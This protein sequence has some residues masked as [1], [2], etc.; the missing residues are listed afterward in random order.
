MLRESD[1]PAGY[2]FTS[3]RSE[4]G[5]AARY[6]AVDRECELDP[7]VASTGTPPD[8][9]SAGFRGAGGHGTEILYTFASTTSAVT[10]FRNFDR[11]F[12]GLG[13]CGKAISPNGAIGTYEALALG[14]V[15]DERSGLA[16]DPSGRVPHAREDSRPT[17]GMTTRSRAAAVPEHWSM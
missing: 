12:E 15:G 13:E 1:L 3:F 4:T 14:K 5:R 11:G 17:G 9:A 16:F 8:T 7:S 2:A 6:P 10:Y